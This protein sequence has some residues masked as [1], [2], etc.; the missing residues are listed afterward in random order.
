MLVVP[1]PS[2]MARPPPAIVATAGLPPPHSSSHV[3][4]VQ[5]RAELQVRVVEQR[6]CHRSY[7]TADSCC[8][9][10][11]GFASCHGMRFTIVIVIFDR[12]LTV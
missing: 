2:S 11:A 6:R 5:Y 9:C 3:V 10:E 7:G 8:K 12:I 4:L 1:T